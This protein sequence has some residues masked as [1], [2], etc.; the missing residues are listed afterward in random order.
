MKERTSGTFSLR[1]GGILE[2]V[3]SVRSRVSQEGFRNLKNDSSGPVVS[4]KSSWNVCLRINSKMWR[5][6]ANH[7]SC[8]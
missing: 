3:M 6:L 5:L 1:E 7:S 8:L 2:R 4:P